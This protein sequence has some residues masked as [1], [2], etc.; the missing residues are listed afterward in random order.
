MSELT[1][2]KM[3]FTCEC[4]ARNDFPTY[5][6]EHRNVKLVY[7]CVCKRQY[8]LYQGAVSKLAQGTLE[9]PDEDEFGG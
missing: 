2:D 1:Y 5:I 3:G 9:N 6:Q 8:V 4:G 7:S